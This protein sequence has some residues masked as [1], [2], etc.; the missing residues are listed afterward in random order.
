MSNRLANAVLPYVLDDDQSSLCQQKELSTEELK[1][2]EA[3]LFD[4]SME[5]M[6]DTYW[7]N[8]DFTGSEVT[9]IVKPS[10]EKEKP[11]NDYERVHSVKVCLFSNYVLWAI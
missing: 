8:A 1:V 5:L 2:K 7:K 9:T 11:Y 6:R 4:Q 10:L 3:Q